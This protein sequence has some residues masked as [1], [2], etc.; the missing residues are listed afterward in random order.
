MVSDYV[1][2]ISKSIERQ[3][4]TVINK[5]IVLIELIIVIKTQ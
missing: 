1:N 2:F 3:A 4:F 5:N